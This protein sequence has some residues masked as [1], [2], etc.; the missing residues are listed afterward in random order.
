MDMD[1][2]IRVFSHTSNDFLVCM[3]VCMLHYITL[4]THDMI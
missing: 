4:H 2:D 1:M 3:Y